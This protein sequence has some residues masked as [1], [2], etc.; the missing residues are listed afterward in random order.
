MVTF[1]RPFWIGDSE[2]TNTQFARFAPDHDSGRYAKRLPRPDGKGLTLSE[3]DQPVVRVSWHEA[4]AFCRWLSEK[5]GV[6]F[7]LPTE[8][9]WEYACRAGS[10]D[11]LAFGGTDTDFSP[12]A[13]L[14]DATFAHAIMAPLNTHPKAVSQWSGGVPHLVL[15]GANLASDRFRDGFSVTAPVRSFRPNRWGLYDM[16]GNA[17]EWTRSL[18]RPYAY[19]DDDG[20]NGAETEGRYAAEGEG[21]RVVRGGSFFEPP[22]RARAAVRLSYPGWRRVFNVGFRVVCA[23]P[24]SSAAM[25]SRDRGDPQAGRFDAGRGC[26]RSV[27]R[28]GSR[29]GA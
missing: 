28:G 10:A 20:R 21:R 1:D 12:W 3:P 9:Q 11:A 27:R 19:R 6:R 7:D 2:I 16:H 23:E 14:A 8:A 5:T 15:E 25:H 24:E 29:Y 13:N 22:R 18:Y 17:A 26:S 4:R